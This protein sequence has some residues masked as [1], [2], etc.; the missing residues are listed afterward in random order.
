VIGVVVTGGLVALGSGETRGKTA[1]DPER[2]VWMVRIISSETSH[3]FCPDGV[4]N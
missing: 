4:G 3:R 2:V 1:V